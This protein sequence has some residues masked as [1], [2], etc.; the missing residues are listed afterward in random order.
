[1]G[2]H[3][4]G[5]AIVLTAV[6][7]VSTP[8]SAQPAFDHLQCFPI[9]DSLARGAAT[10]DL[11]PEQG[12]P[13]ATQSGCT[14]K[15]PARYY[16]TDVRKENL[17]PP[18]ASS[19]GGGDAR[20]YFCYRLACPR[21]TGP[22]VG[23][24]LFAEDQFGGRTITLRKGTLFCVP[25]VRPTPT[26]TPA[27]T[28]DSDPGCSFDGEQCQGVCG[29]FACLYDPNQNRCICPAV[30]DI[31]CDQFAQGTCGGHLCRRPDESCFPDPQSTLG[32]GCR[33]LLPSPQPTP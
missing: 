13:F 24:G 8:A 31:A 29:T 3:R 25:A 14:I 4:L 6:F 2:T 16:C 23:A 9:K 21:G 18:P 32:P 19:V 10:A 5:C 17:Q 12:P 1:M 15:L 27:P 22:A 26:P 7:M 28:P 11:V 33:C 20:D 30:F